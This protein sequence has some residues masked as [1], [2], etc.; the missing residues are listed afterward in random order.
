MCLMISF[1]WMKTRAPFGWCG[2]QVCCHKACHVHMQYIESAVAGDAG[3]GLCCTSVLSPVIPGDGRSPW[4]QKILEL[5]PCILPHCIFN[6]NRYSHWKIPYLS[7]I[8]LSLT[9]ILFHYI[10]HYM[11]NITKEKKNLVTVLSL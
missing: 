9:N 5:L 8:D 10:H 7:S 6:S 1:I 4:A 11:Y 2:R 3:R